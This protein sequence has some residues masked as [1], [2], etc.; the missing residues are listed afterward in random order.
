MEV[1]KAT[2]WG[3]LTLTLSQRARGSDRLRGS[4]EEGVNPGPIW[5]CLALF[6]PSGEAGNE[7]TM[8]SFGATLTLTLSQRERGPA[9]G[10]PALVGLV[11]SGQEWQ[12]L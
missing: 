1:S 7:A 4:D 3:T 2:G 9:A 8:A 10:Q 6:T 12:N 5:P 11:T